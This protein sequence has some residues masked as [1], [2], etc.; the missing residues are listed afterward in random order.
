MGLKMDSFWTHASDGLTMT[1]DNQ[2]LKPD[3]VRRP[4]THDGLLLSDS[5]LP[6]HPGLLH[7]GQL[8]DEQLAVGL[9][10][11]RNIGTVLVH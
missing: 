6:R 3:S 9:R 5:R 2:W 10:P 4:R 7:P 8:L 11:R 1:P